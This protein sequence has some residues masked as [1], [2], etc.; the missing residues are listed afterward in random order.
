MEVVAVISS[1]AGIATLVGQSV[2][3]L[4]KLYNFFEECRNASKKTNRFLNEINSLRQT[5]LQVEELISKIS[6][7]FEPSGTS[8]LASLKIHLED[9]AKDVTRWLEVAEKYIPS[10]KLKS[11]IYFKN[12]LLALKSR[13]IADI[14]EQIS[15]H[16]HGITLSLSA[17]GR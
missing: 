11:K 12:F 16:Q 8:V 17:T 14:F 9:C 7:G 10:P 2:A 13:E 1:V 15:S 3:G 4:T 5:V 6:A